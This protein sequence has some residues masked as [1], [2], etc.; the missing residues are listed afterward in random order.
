[1]VAMEPATVHGGSREDWKARGEIRI[2]EHGDS[3]DYA[4]DITPH[5]GEAAIA[6]LKKRLA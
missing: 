5:A 6:D 2:L 1:M 3:W 4:L